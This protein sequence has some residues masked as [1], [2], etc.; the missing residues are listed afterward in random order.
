MQLM[1]YVKGN[2]ITVNFGDEKEG[3]IEYTVFFSPEGNVPER[4]VERLLTRHPGEF[5]KVEPKVEATV[6]PKV[7]PKA[8]CDVCQKEFKN[9]SGVAIHK[10]RK[11]K[12]T[13]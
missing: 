13:T 2:E 4:L 12:E 8:V 10:K 7:E 11:H 6:E 5:E 3:R 9:Q 1:K